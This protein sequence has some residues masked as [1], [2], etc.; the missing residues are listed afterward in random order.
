M[1]CWGC[2]VEGPGHIM[3]YSAIIPYNVLYMI[4]FYKQ[5]YNML[6]PTIYDNMPR[7]YPSST[8]I[9]PSAAASVAQSD[10]GPACPADWDLRRVTSVSR[11]GAKKGAFVIKIGLL[12]CIKL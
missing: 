1:G 12:R 5:E 10:R 6:D 3:L 9:N 11:L 4:Y 2:G 8:I 7:I